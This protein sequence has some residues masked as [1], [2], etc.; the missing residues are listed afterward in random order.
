MKVMCK[1]FVGKDLEGFCDELPPIGLFRWKVYFPLKDVSDLLANNIF[2][3]CKDTDDE[4]V[5]VFTLMQVMVKATHQLVNFEINDWHVNI[6]RL[7]ESK[8]HLEL[9]CVFYI[10]YDECKFISSETNESVYGESEFIS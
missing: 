5:N 10:N 6:I 7:L 2:K 1:N 3:K 9:V 8:D 4:H